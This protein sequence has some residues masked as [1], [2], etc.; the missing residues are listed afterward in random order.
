[1]LPVN[2]VPV[3]QIPTG[4]GTLL[5]GLAL[6]AFIALVLGYFLHR[7][8]EAEPTIAVP[9]AAPGPAADKPSRLSA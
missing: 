5:G 1:M 6:G 3:L 9:T 8:E 2:P 4:I 7:R